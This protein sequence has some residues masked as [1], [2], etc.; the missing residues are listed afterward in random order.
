MTSFNPM[1]Y[2]LAI[3]DFHRLRR[4]AVLEKI[5]ARLTGRS[6]DLLSFEDV[7]KKLKLIGSSASGLQEIPLNAIVGSV[8]RYTDFTRKF[9]PKRDSDEGRWAHVKMAVSDLLGLPPIEVYQIGEVYFVLDGNHRV[10]VAQQLGATH[11]QAYVTEIRTKVPLSPDVQPDDLILKE[12]YVE[13][14]ERTQLDRFRPEADWS[15]TAPGRY[16]L[17]AEHIAV[18]RY[19]MGLEQNREIPYEEAVTHWYDKVYLPVVEIIREQ[20]ILRDFPGRTETDLYLWFSKHRT[21]LEKALGWEIDPKVMA[22]HLAAR[23]SSRPRRVVARVGEKILDAITPDELEAGPSP[24]E[25]RKKH[26]KTHR[27]ERL[28]PEILVPIND[29][30]SGWHALDQA[31]EIAQ[32]EDS[33]LLGLHIVPSETQK[34]SEKVKAIQVE[35]ANRCTEAGVSGELAID[36]GGIARRICE[37]APWVDLVVI[38]LTHPPAPQP[39]AKLGSGFRT[40]IRRCPR[41]LLAVPSFSSVIDQA[42][43]AYDGSPK[44]NEALFIATYLSGSWNI[45]L[46]VVTIKERGRATAETLT[47]ARKYLEARGIQATYVRERGLVP[48]AILKTADEYESNMIIMGGYGKSP[49]TEI[50]LGSA[51]DRVLREAWQPMLICR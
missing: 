46:V 24:G 28:F 41:P 34:E 1:S 47:D 50:L 45:P 49:A 4:R 43:L 22:S 44:A 18:H 27:D 17:L 30:E 39:I 26:L 12:E 33:R 38:N 36:V 15:V 5:M 10:S 25:W 35:F 42:L 13:F 31:L 8:G 2:S 23:T 16:K 48:E 29:D 11:I 7:R 40:I 32:R 20:G 21:T 14:L 37:R 3:G 19:F 9:L 51:V 6:A